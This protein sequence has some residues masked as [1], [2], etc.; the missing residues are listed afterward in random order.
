MRLEISSVARARG[1]RDEPGDVGAGVGDELLGAVDHPLAVLERARVRVLPASEPASGSVSP[2]APS[3][4]PG[5]ELG[6]PL[7]FCSS[8]AEQVDR[9]G[10]ERGV[11]AQRDRDRRVHARELLDR[12]RVGERVRARRRRTPRGT[13]SPSSRGRRACGRSRR[14]RTWCGRAPRRPARPPARRTRGPCGGSGR[15]RRRGRSP[16]G[17]L[18]DCGASS[19]SSRHADRARPCGPCRGGRCRWPCRRCRGAPR[20]RRRRSAAGTRR[21]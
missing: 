14:G 2:K 5:A 7:R 18:C 19:T 13:G 12:E 20:G 11:C 9:L 1:D 17:G 10:P 16:S 6:Q 15:G 4:R 3:L 8:V 21:R